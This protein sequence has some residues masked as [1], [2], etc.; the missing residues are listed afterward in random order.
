[1]KHTQHTGT[2]S[3]AD[4]SED[5]CTLFATAFLTGQDFQKENYLA[6]PIETA[7]PDALK[8][9]GSVQQANKGFYS[10]DPIEMRFHLLKS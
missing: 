8:F 1:M 4:A 7:T 9:S 5:V 2:P 6:C 10:N 3:N